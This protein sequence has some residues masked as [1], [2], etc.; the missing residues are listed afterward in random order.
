MEGRIA[1][2]AIW[3][4]ALSA[5]DAASLAA[6]A[7]PLTIRR[8]ALVGYW[9]LRDAD[10]DISAVNAYT[11]TPTNSPTYGDHIWAIRR[12]WIMSVGP[13]IV[14]NPKDQVHNFSVFGVHSP[15]YGSIH[16]L[17]LLALLQPSLHLLNDLAILSVEGPGRSS[18]ANLSVLAVTEPTQDL[19]LSFAPEV[20]INEKLAWETH[21]LSSLTDAEQRIAERRYPRHTL[22]LTYVLAEDSRRY[23]ESILA[24]GRQNSVY[25]PQ[26]QEPLWLTAT[27]SAGASTLNTS[28]TNTADIRVGDRLFISY[29]D[30]EYDLLPISAVGANS[31][32]VSS[33]TLREWPSGTMVCA[34]RKFAIQ[35]TSSGDR[36]PN[37]ALT[38]SIVAN[39]LDH[40]VD[41][42]D[43]SSFATQDGLIFL[44]N[45]N[46]IDGDSKREY[47]VQYL[48]LD[49]PAS[50]LRYD[51]R[52]SQ[53]KVT[54]HQG[55]NSTTP[56][57]RRAIKGLLYALRGR[58]VAFYVPLH[59][60]SLVASA[61]T[62]GTNYVDVAKSGLL[63]WSAH[64]KNKLRTT[65][66]GTAYVKSITAVQEVNT[67]TDRIYLDSNWAAS[68][69]P[70]RVE[71]VELVRST[72]DSFTI[73]HL[74]QLGNSELRF[75]VTSVLDDV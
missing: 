62:S 40:A 61:V 68:G 53:S 67:T 22:E 5:D 46:A 17:S 57:G 7:S 60:E 16:N 69:T 58:Q 21:V 14:S 52:W 20:E 49:S 6:G 26:W 30:T 36:S 72:S 15:N 37:E 59:E 45:P 35:P 44:T 12:P 39:S 2:A 18:V 65:L 56:A 64:A 73:R 34:A 31:I 38:I 1:E 25:V 4:V 11:M 33:P 23:M 55:L 41:L 27:A 9:P 70:T 24:S 63:D 10:G 29:S 8:D 28:A 32:T 74:D 19:V 71:Y 66:G 51:T 43:S 54:S 48:Q 3:N 75:T 50:R 42:A 13:A 47:T